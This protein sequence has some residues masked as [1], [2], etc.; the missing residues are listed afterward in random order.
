MNPSR[1]ASM[2]INKLA[3]F[4]FKSDDN[5]RTNTNCIE[6]M[7]HIAAKDARTL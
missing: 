3:R 5:L 1:E 6:F 4:Y 7:Q 2:H